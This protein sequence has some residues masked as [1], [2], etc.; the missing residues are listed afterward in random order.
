MKGSF[1]M[2]KYINQSE[3]VFIIGGSFSIP[4]GEAIEL[5]AAQEL[6][7]QAHISANELVKAPETVDDDVSIDNMTLPQLKECAAGNNIDLGQATKKEDIIA[8]IKAAE[9][10]K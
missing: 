2:S 7:A 5:T 1:Q 8:I 9:P 10:C 6:E 3:R 4:G